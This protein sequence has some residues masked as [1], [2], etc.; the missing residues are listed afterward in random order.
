M[1]KDL[2][3]PAPLPVFRIIGDAIQFVWD[4]KFRM[5]QALLIPAAA[6]LILKH[7]T[8]LTHSISSDPG[9][10]GHALFGWLSFLIQAA[11]YGLFAITCHR[12]ALIGDHS[13]PDYGL[14]IWTPR[15]SRYLGWFF[16]VLIVWLLFSFV[17]NSIY[18][19]AI[20]KDVEAGASVESFESTRR[21]LN[22]LYIPLVYILCRLSVLYP[23]IAVDQPVTAQWAWRFTAHNGLRLGVI[24][25][26]LPGV[27]YY[28]MS[29]LTRDTA[30]FA[31]SAI[32]T[33]IG[34]ILMAVE[35]VALSFSYKHL[36]AT[37]A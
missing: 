14:K 2:S 27:L 23:A 8:P 36:A 28:F 29:F 10:S 4:K 21:W 31:E 32:L 9:F 15:E 18:V 37:E 25:G 19:S 13:V 20:I 6:L 22:L 16:V 1:D 17:V 7:T 34:F 26:I 35:I 3:T 33:L 24:V 11:L 12:L 5:F 30:T